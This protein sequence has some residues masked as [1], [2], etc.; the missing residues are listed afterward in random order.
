MGILRVSV[1]T[2]PRGSL[3]ALSPF[4]QRSFKQVQ[5]MADAERRGALSSQISTGVVGDSQ[6]E[7]F[8]GALS[9]QA[10]AGFSPSGGQ[11][12]PLFKALSAFAALF[13]AGHDHLC[14]VLLQSLA[15]LPET[16]MEGNGDSQIVR[17]PQGALKTIQ[18]HVVHCLRVKGMI[19]HFYLKKKKEIF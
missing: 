8:G 1:S 15:V 13:Q 3:T 5:I 2:F 12:F 16:N 18:A 17:E 14:Q 11:R 10:A 4:E 9:L 19:Y 7:V 6:V